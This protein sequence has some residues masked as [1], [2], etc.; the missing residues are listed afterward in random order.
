MRFKATVTQSVE[1]EILADSKQ[2]AHQ[3]AIDIVM[4]GG[5][6]LNQIVVNLEELHDDIQ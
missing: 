3:M 2:Q 1:F 6:I 5:E 4:S